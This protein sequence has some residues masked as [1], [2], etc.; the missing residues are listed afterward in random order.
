MDDVSELQLDRKLTILFKST[1]SLVTKPFLGSG[2]RSKEETRELV[3]AIQN[4]KPPGP[5]PIYK[6]P[7]EKLVNFDVSLKKM[8]LNYY[9]T[10]EASLER[11][12]PI[13][14]ARTTA[15]T[16]T[17]AVTPEPARQYNSMYPHLADGHK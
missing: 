4:L 10:D 15:S 1:A 2:R 17:H 13:P 12:S 16:R 8:I 9:S 14:A 7:P 5:T 3:E 6:G 11:S